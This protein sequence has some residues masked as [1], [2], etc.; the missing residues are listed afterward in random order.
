M[1]CIVNGLGEMADA[2]GKINLYVGKNCVEKGIDFDSA[3]ERLIGLIKSHN[4]WVDP[5]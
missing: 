5:K 4:K 1:G 2:P 3:D